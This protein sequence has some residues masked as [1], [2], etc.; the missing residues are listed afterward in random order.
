MKG[1]CPGPAK[2]HVHRLP[3]EVDTKPRSSLRRGCKINASVG[4]GIQQTPTLA[5][6]ANTGQV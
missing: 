6:N 4:V 2:V 5:I 3:D 1:R